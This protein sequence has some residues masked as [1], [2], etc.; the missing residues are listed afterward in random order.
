MFENLIGEFQL[1][2]Q[3]LPTPLGRGAA[4]GITKDLQQLTKDI[5]AVERDYR[6]ERLTAERQKLVDGFLTQHENLVTHG[7]QLRQQAADLLPV[8]KNPYDFAHLA[9]IRAV[10]RPGVM[11]YA[12]DGLPRFDVLKVQNLLQTSITQEKLSFTWAILDAPDTWID[13]ATRTAALA[14]LSALA[15]PAKAAEQQTMLRD[16]RELESQFNRLKRGMERS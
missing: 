2:A 8:A 7:E 16:A 12:Q 13:D 6:G 5:T 15:H 4:E 1:L 14:Q 9:E 11:T 3:M 10:L